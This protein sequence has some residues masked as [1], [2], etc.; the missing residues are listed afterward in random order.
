[1]D[2]ISKR[3]GLWRRSCPTLVTPPLLIGS[4]LVLRIVSA[5]V[6]AHKPRNCSLFPPPAT[7]AC[8]HCSRSE[9]FLVA[10]TARCACSLLL[11]PAVLACRSCHRPIAVVAPVNTPMP[12][13]ILPYSTRCSCSL[14]LPP[15]VL[16]QLASPNL[17]FRGIVGV[18]DLGEYDRSRSVI[19]G[20]V[21]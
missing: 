20:F 1:M 3:A 21:N 5:T 14:F 16:G 18:P 10:S 13:R 12:R 19:D 7:P 15:A 8:F 9:S 4:P 11:P 2:I 17:L 6:S